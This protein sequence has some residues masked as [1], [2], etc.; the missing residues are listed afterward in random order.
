M[1]AA[2]FLMF[3]LLQARRT[4]VEVQL[5]P[6]FLRALPPTALECLVFRLRFQK[7]KYFHICM[8]ASLLGLDQL[9][10]AGN[11]HISTGTQ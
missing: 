11:E 4:F 1:M 8:F 3:I 5:K 2:S 10:S 9:I 6:I 7:G